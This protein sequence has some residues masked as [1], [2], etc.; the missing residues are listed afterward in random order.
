M[1]TINVRG[2]NKAYKDFTY[3]RG[4]IS[5]ASI[6]SKRECVC[7]RERERVGEIEMVRENV[8]ERESDRVK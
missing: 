6:L 1:F 7:E 2:P 3:R 5:D 4:V 8:R